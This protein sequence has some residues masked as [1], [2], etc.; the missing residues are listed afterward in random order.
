MREP[1]SPSPALA[2]PLPGSPALA[3]P[4]P[5]SPAPPPPLRSEEA[6][7]DAGLP[8]LEDILENPAAIARPQAAAA[9]LLAAAAA[10]AVPNAIGGPA[11]GPAAGTAA[12]GGAGAGAGAA[13]AA[14]AAGA[15]P[16]APLV[17]SDYSPLRL[18]FRD[19][20]TQFMSAQVH[21]EARDGV[22][23]L[24]LLVGSLQCG[25]LSV[26]GNEQRP[27]TFR[28]F[29][30]PYMADAHTHARAHTFLRVSSLVPSDTHARKHARPPAA[31]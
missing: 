15:A 23:L 25:A 2:R 4:L 11:G 27:T 31:G 6:R 7:Q 21:G 30:I 10:A 1:G 3:W 17:L 13:A 5:G 26:V 14:A 20:D 29:I 24:V 19:Y 18:A 9:G 8:L 12:G 16:P 22:V 28:F